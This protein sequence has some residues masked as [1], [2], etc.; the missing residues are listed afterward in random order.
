MSGSPDFK[1]ATAIVGSPSNVI[2]QFGTLALTADTSLA[3]SKGLITNSSG[4]TIN[5]TLPTS[6][7]IEGEFLIDATNPIVLVPESGED[8]IFQIIT[9]TNPIPILFV[10]LAGNATVAAGQAGYLKR[11]GQHWLLIQGAKAS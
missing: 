2:K 8:V 6:D 9:S 1:L 10:P 5:L 11:I 3:I 4:G 7:H